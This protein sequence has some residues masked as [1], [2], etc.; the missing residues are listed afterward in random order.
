[1]SDGQ[2]L[3]EI[4][5]S[6]SA[7]VQATP[8]WVIVAPPDFA[9]AT[10]GIV[11]LFD[12]MRQAAIERRELKLPVKPSFKQD[13]WPMLRRAAGLR[14]VNSQPHWKTFSSDWKRLS[15]PAVSEKHLRADNAE[16][17]RQVASQGRLHNFHLR[18]WQETYLQAWEDGN[19]SNDFD[20]NLPDTGV[21]SPDVL[22]RTVLDGGVGQGFFPGIEAGVIITNQSIYAEP[23]RIGAT[24][25]PG[26]LTALMA[27]PW[28]ADFLKCNGKW[29]PSQRPD[30]APQED[31]PVN[32]IEEWARSIDD[33]RALV[34]N[35]GR[36]GFIVSKEINGGD[37]FVEQDRD[38][39]F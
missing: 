27:L 12:V 36:L 33:H 17:L 38:P 11:T 15:D 20:G 16:R 18:S 19:F 30:D 28:Q 5:F 21:L 1:M 7:P 22:T 13:I 34:N 25:A 10:Q 26:D 3:A 23:F 29:W 35:F 8:A 6:G 9:P 37:A 14:W 24:V 31:D 39:N 32:H 2:V 4:T